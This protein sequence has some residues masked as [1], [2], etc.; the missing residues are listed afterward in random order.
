MPQFSGFNA[1]SISNLINRS[2]LFLIIIKEMSCLAWSGFELPLHWN[3]AS[4]DFN[5]ILLQCILEA[6]LGLELDVGMLID[7]RSDSLDRSA[8]LEYILHNNLHVIEPIGRE[9]THL[10]KLFS[11][12]SRSLPA[13]ELFFFL[14]FTRLFTFVR[15]ILCFLHFKILFSFY[16]IIFFSLGF[17]NLLSFGFLILYYG[18]LILYYGLLSL[19]CLLIFWCGFKLE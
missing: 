18:L 17:E 11:S 4:D 12:L 1:K 9:H 10:V 6:L 2:P 16:L 15:W 8:L 7:E 14:H 13:F 5:L 3:F 19:W